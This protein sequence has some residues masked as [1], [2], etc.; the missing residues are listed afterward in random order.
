MVL[1]MRTYT[2]SRSISQARVQLRKWKTGGLRRVSKEQ[3]FCELT[4]TS[5]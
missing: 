1:S 2:L 3:P 5:H 4:D